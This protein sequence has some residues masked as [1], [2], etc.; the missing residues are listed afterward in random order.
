MKYLCL[1]YENEKTYETMPKEEADAVFGEYF[2]FKQRPR[3]AS[4]T[5]RSRR[6][7]VRSRKR[8]NSSAATT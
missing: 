5:E 7:T 2:S 8:R 6:P 3:S 4:A 1:I